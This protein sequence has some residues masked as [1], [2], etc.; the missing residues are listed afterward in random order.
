MHPPDNMYIKQIKSK[1]AHDQVLLKTV[2]FFLD[3]RS[4][5]FFFFFEK[6]VRRK[7]RKKKRNVMKG[8]NLTIVAGILVN[9]AMAMKDLFENT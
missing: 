7:K 9:E 5:D 2:F 3:Q 4:H 1:S 8:I 6:E